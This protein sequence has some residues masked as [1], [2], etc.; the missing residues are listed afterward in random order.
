MTAPKL[1]QF[2]YF[3]GLFFPLL[4]TQFAQV[5]SNLFSSIFSGNAGTIDLAGVA[6]AANI[7]FPL[8]A[9][10]C[11]IAFGVSPII[12]QLRGAGK[13]E[14]IPV[15]IMQGIYIAVALTLI[16]LLLGK[17]FLKPF[18]GFLHL[19][20]AVQ[21]ISE[22]Y[23]FALA[24]GVLPLFVQATLRYVVDAHGM[25]KLSMAVLM[26]N[27]ILTVALFGLFVF[28]GFG[29]PALGGAG[30]G[31]AISLAAWVTCIAF[32]VILHFKKPFSNYRL[33][34]NIRSFSWIYCREQLR[35]GLP[36]FVA[37][38]CETSLFSIV[39]LLMSEFGTLYIAANQ[40]AISYSTLV[41]T[42][43]WSISLTAT[44][45]VGYEAGAKNRKGALQY[46]MIC[47]LTSLT[48]VCIT[49]FLTYT[50]LGDIAAIFT[51]DLETF[52]A[53]RNFL[54]FALMFSVFDALGTPVQG[55]LRGYKDV[56]VITYVAF[57]TYW[58][59]AIPLGYVLAHYTP[60][61]PYGYWLSLV[62]SL[63]INAFALNGR[64]WFFTSRRPL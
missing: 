61:G 13:E 4:L 31:Y 26:A 42:L 52:R 63:A 48:A 20:P 54:I 59:I 41:Y 29:I 35:L 62:I 36:I 5:G 10:S 25:T 18:L 30:T 60:Y 57:V 58:L 44:I 56:K 2:T 55:M 19:N 16:I 11:G 53:I 47:S 22:E 12:A 50:F 51:H 39:G 34:T 24:F 40:A 23:L 38:F 37:I 49:A 1:R 6:V 9:G 28:G 7:W 3:L 14:V 46:D 21:S 43:P 15:Y 8:F 45:V 27:M 33:W 64:L 32:M 17:V